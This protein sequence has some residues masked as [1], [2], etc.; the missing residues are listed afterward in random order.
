MG[1]I[2][3]FIAV[4]KYVKNKAK[5]ESVSLSET[6]VEYCEVVEPVYET[7]KTAN[8]IQQIKNNV[9]YEYKKESICNINMCKSNEAYGL[10]PTLI[11]TNTREFY[12]EFSSINF[13]EVVNFE[14]VHKHNISCNKHPTSEITQPCRYDNTSISQNHVI[15]SERQGDFLK[16]QLP[17][18]FPQL[19]VDS[20]ASIKTV[21]TPDHRSSC[22]FTQMQVDESTRSFSREKHTSNPEDVESHSMYVQPVMTISEPID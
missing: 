9:A 8:S 22:L 5:R 12:E 16:E 7:L 3:I 2:I 11:M 14:D 10:P 1:L 18:C 19:H 4:W 21:S 13:C 20:V 17:Q 15:K 6:N